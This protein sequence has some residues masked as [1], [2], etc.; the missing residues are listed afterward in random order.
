MTVTAGPDL[1]V[2]RFVH[3][4]LLTE[5]L[6]VLRTLAKNDKMELLSRL[7]FAIRQLLRRDVVSFY[8]EETESASIQDGGLEW[9][10]DY[11]Q[12]FAGEDMKYVSKLRVFQALYNSESD[13]LEGLENEDYWKTA[14]VAWENTLSASISK[15]IQVSL[16][17]ELLYD[18]EMDLR[19]RFRE[20]FGLGVAYKFF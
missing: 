19:G 6:G 17:F 14:D 13:D 12:T 3:P 20:V 11:S 10:T 5:S 18:K 8:P 2:N 7:G 4:I 9:V 16:F 1:T 15:Y